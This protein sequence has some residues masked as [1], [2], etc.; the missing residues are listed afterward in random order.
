MNEKLAIAVAALD[1]RRNDAAY[2][3]AQSFD[4]A[5]DA[6]ANL[7]VNFLVA[8][9]ALLHRGAPGFE[10]RLDQRDK[11]GARRGERKDLRQQDA[12][13]MKL[14]SITIRLGA[15]VKMR[16]RQRARV[17]PFERCHARIAAQPRMQL[18][19]TDVDGDDMARAAR[20]QNVGEAARRGAD[21][22]TEAPVGSTPNCSSA[23]ASFTPPRD[24]QG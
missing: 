19:V 11:I 8:H 9:H 1:R 13:E 14:A 17:L 10:L 22:E 18:P 24:T 23:C 7:C 3:P 5:F 16:R 12:S 4:F 20:Q 2:T 21:V 6:R 15:S